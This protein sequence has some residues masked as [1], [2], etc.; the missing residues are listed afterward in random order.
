MHHDD[1]AA[2]GVKALMLQAAATPPAMGRG[3]SIIVSPPSTTSSSSTSALDLTADVWSCIAAHCGK[4]G[5]LVP[6]LCRATSGAWRGVLSNE[7]LMATVVGLSQDPHETMILAARQGHAGALRLLSDPKRHE[8]CGWSC[9]RRA[10][11]NGDQNVVRELLRAGRG[12][13]PATHVLMEAA[14]ESEQSSS[15]QVSRGVFY[16]GNETAACK[17]IFRAGVPC[18]KQAVVGGQ[19]FPTQQFLPPPTHTRAACGP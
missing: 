15:V 10:V 9:L 11:V 8:A 2:V 13:G 19:Y 4:E 3:G 14:V 6:Q 17:L 1:A 5:V 16:E 7:C 12:P 18:A